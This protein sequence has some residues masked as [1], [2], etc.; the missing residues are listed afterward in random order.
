M[1]FLETRQTRSEERDKKMNKKQRQQIQCQKSGVSPPLKT[2][3]GI[4]KGAASGKSRTEHHPKSRTNAKLMANTKHSRIPDTKKNKKKSKTQ[5]SDQKYQ[6]PQTE[7]VVPKALNQKLQK[8]P[9]L[10]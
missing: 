10:V 8:V 7:K 3:R 6:K 5:K 1:V 4:T 2:H 9:S